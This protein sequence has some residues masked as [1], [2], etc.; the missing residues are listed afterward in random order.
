MVTTQ[1]EGSQIV[2]ALKLG[3]DDYLTKPIDKQ[4]AWARIE[5]RLQIKNLGDALEKER[6]TRLEKAKLDTLLEMAGSMAHEINN[7]LTILFGKLQL[8]EMNNK[9]KKNEEMLNTMWDCMERITNVVNSLRDFAVGPEKDF[10]KKLN[11]EEIIQNTIQIHNKNIIKF[12]INLIYTKSNI[13]EKVLG[14]K[15]PLMQVIYNI[16][17]NSIEA[18]K[19]TND[20]WIK[21]NSVLEENHIKISIMDSGKGIPEKIQKN[22]FL[23]FFTTKEVGDGMGL[24]L[25]ATKGIVENYGG[26][27]TL[28]EKEKNTCFVITLPFDRPPL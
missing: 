18:I 2:E 14:H 13:K 24:G 11:I 5:N 19:G 1:D 12:D 4:V 3:A 16:I 8:M 23:P 10:E 7:P 15:G 26:S 22:I 21:I 25:S 9:D 6:A 28:N 20:P 17:K 27:L